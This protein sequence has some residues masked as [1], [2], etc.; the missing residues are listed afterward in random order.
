MNFLLTPGAPLYREQLRARAL[1]SWRNAA[2]LVSLEWD[3]YLA[4]DGDARSDAFAAYE[5]ALDAERAAADELEL[6]NLDQAA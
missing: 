2:M 4:A 3:A 5:A 6:L 1:D